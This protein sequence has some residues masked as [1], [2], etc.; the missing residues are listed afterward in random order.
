MRIKP[1]LLADLRC[2]NRETPL[3]LAAALP[4]PLVPRVLAACTTT[5]RDDLPP[6]EHTIPDLGSAVPHLLLPRGAIDLLLADPAVSGPGALPALHGPR[7]S[8]WYVTQWCTQL[9][10]HRLL[11]ECAPGFSR[12]TR[13]D[14]P[15]TP[16]GEG[17]FFT[18]W[19]NTLRRIGFR[20]LFRDS[21]PLAR[22]GGEPRP[23]FLLLARADRH[24]ARLAW[25]VEDPAI[26]GLT[27]FVRQLFS[28]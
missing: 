21:V 26:Q 17:A 13:G 28:Q 11:I 9:R 25:P 12:W 14:L 1:V 27:P 2:G 8:P 10:V 18:A 16:T 3:S 7:R 6:A 24:R 5:A 20:V 15:L 4:D 22:E 23:R 19:L